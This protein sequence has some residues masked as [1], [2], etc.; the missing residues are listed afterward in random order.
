M[1]TLFYF[2]YGSN[3]HPIRLGK[4]VRSARPMGPAALNGYELR[5]HK[6][7]FLDGSGK[8]TLTPAV[9]G[10]M[11][12]AIYSV[13]AEDRAILDGLEGVGKGYEVVE[14]S[15]ERDGTA[16]SCF[17]YLATR[18]ALD[19]SLL[20][21]DWYKQLVIAGAQHYSFPEEY[22]EQIRRVAEIKDENLERVA[23]H[24]ELLEAMLKCPGFLE[25]L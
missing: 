7:G 6:R 5:F 10:T 19:R 21:Y 16:Y 20:P 18:D 8:C 24:R 2:A 17:S 1:A 14:L 12:G 4:R 9:D 15:L 3:L 22:I 23:E 13:N 11:H 25:K